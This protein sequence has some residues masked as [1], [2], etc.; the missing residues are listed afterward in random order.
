MITLLLDMF[1]AQV[2]AA[3][4][5]SPLEF[6]SARSCAC[7]A[8]RSRPLH[9]FRLP[10]YSASSARSLCPLAHVLPCT[11]GILCC[12]LLILVLSLHILLVLY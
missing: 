2:S 7:T 5:Y 8:S 4:S 6:S 3:R 9:P 12:Y 11:S 1:Q 10:I